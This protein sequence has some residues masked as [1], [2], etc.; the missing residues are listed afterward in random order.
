MIDVSKKKQKVVMDQYKKMKI[1]SVLKKQKHM[2]GGLIIYGK[3]YRE[4]KI[5]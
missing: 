5:K 2:Y 1:F 4:S 3:I